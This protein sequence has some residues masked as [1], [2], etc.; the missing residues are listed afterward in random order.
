MELLQGH[1][2][3]CKLGPDLQS[4]RPLPTLRRLRNSTLRQRSCHK[5]EPCTSCESCSRTSLQKQSVSKPTN[6]QRSREQ[7]NRLRAK[8]QASADPAWCLPPLNDSSSDSQ[9]PWR[10]ILAVLCTAVVVLLWL[11]HSSWVSTPGVGFLSASA[12]TLSSRAS[13]PGQARPEL[14]MAAEI[15]LWCMK[16]V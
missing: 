5:H 13:Q 4:V 12:A 14:Q 9:N 2:S 7:K 10:P 1:S 6:G 11:Q 15:S 3:G 16:G 8:A